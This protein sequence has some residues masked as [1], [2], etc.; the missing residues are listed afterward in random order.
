MRVVSEQVNGRSLPVLPGVVPRHESFSKE[1]V[2]SSPFITFEDGLIELKLHNA[3]L[4]YRV[5]SQAQDMPNGVPGDIWYGADLV[6][7]VERYDVTTID[8]EPGSS[9]VDGRVQFRCSQ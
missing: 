1:L 3:R 6:E 7:W 5:T 4:V 9:Y 8:Q 2:D